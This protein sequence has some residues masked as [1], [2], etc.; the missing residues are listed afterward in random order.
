M[1]RDCFGGR[2]TSSD[3]AATAAFE[4]AVVELVAHRPSI[5]RALDTA[6]ALDPAFVAAHALK[7]ICTLILARGELTDPARQALEAARSAAV[8]RREI[9]A[10]EA[11]L[12]AA[13]HELVDGR[14]AAAARHLDAHLRD[15]PRDLVSLK[16]S[17][18]LRF[19]V[20]DAQGMLATTT[21]A[22][23]AWSRSM[24]GYG[25]MLGC[26]AFAL[27]ECGDLSAAEAV[28]HIAIEHEPHDA[29]GLHAVAHVYETQGRAAD[30]I[31]WLER[32]RP[33]W[34][35]CNNFAFHIAWHLALFQIEAGSPERALALYDAQIRP[36][37]TD[38]F[39]DI[40]NAASLLW[41]LDQEG[42]DVGDRWRALRPS[43]LHR[44]LD[45]T[46]VFASLHY[47]LA[48]IG[49]GDL[50]AAHDLAH[51]LARRGL[52]GT[53]D[54]ASI[55]I[56]IG[57]PMASVLLDRRP[58]PGGGADLSGLAARL[59]GLGGS[60][61]QRDV[62]LRTLAL[63]AANLGDG[64]AAMRILA[65]RR[66]PKSDRFA[67]MVEARVRVGLDL[68]AKRRRLRRGTTREQMQRPTAH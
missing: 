18:A 65:M 68:A 4:E 52:L 40:A 61:A 27:E 66:R 38:D 26:H 58:R 11:V 44:H 51:A 1:T 43:A 45:T 8:A 3:Q 16:L 21:T 28:G 34:Q 41:R 46:L 37:Q 48:L 56:S 13:L 31:A 5:A 57:Y 9:T 7:G 36:K 24:P 33:D 14:L 53:E 42:V 67:V 60:H 50:E 35:Q 30:G 59:R 62:F 55:A 32:H 54:Q 20:G 6:L 64:K 2:H 22:L 29:W 17:H 15:S 39:R 23:G 10:T 25:Y 19:I 47:L 49:A 63:V 12:V